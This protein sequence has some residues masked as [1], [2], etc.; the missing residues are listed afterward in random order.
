MKKDKIPPTPLHWIFLEDAQIVKA[1]L[2]SKQIN[3]E[4][5]ETRSKRI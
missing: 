1:S 2:Q 3:N 4:T 5:Q